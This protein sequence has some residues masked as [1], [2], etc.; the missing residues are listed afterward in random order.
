MKSVER[1]SEGLRLL[2]SDQEFDIVFCDLVMPEIS[3]IDLYC[4]L[5]LNRPA[6]T[7]RIVFMTGG[8]FTPEAERFLARVPNAAHR[9]TVQPGARGAPSR[10]GRGKRR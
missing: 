3:G 10:A 4:S 8:V 6:G 9:K 2:L 1:A 7:D 5:E